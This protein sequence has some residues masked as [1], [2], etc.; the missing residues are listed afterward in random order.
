MDKYEGL[1]EKQKSALIVVFT[2]GLA[3]VPLKLNWS[4]NI[5]EG[6]SFDTGVLHILLKFISFIFLTILFAIPAFVIYFFVLIITT[7]KI[8]NIK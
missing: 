8:A 6:T 3:A 5:F 7:I 2:L 4:S 1:K